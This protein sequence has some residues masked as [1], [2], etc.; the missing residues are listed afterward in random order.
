VTPGARTQAAIELLNTILVS[1]Q[2]EKRIPADKLLENYFKTH[3][4][5][6][7]KDRAAVGE[8]VYWVLRHKA[9]LGGLRAR[10]T[11]WMPPGWY[12]PH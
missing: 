5:I 2:S 6:G 7:S 3:R 4:Y 9:S 10:G 11:C 1:W 8:L 12:S